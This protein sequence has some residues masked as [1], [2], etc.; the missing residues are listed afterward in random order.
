MPKTTTFQTD[1]QRLQRR[2]QSLA[3]VAESTVFKVIDENSELLEDFNKKQ[4]RKGLRSDD[5]EITPYYRNI[6]YKGRLKPVDLRNTGAFYESIT[7]TV[8]DN[9][10]DFDATNNKTAEL[11]TKYGE[12]ILG[13]SENNKNVFFD[14][15]KPNINKI[16]FEYLKS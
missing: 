8:Q 7:V 16:L 9:S 5:T 14:R 12:K 1:I 10:V 4:L 2:F 3:V 15:V 13:L 11:Q 6:T